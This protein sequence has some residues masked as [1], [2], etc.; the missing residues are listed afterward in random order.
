MAVRAKSRIK[1]LI[2]QLLL[3]M[4]ERREQKRGKERKGEGRRGRVIVKESERNKE[5]CTKRSDYGKENVVQK[6]LWL[7]MILQLKIINRGD[8]EE[9]RKK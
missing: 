6:F 7:L 8:G 3:S 1:T 2:F 4:Q 5:R 9:K